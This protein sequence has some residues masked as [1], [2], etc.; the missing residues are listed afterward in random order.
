MRQVMKMLHG[1]PLVVLLAAGCAV[2]P[3]EPPQ[4]LP[5]PTIEIQPKQVNGS[6]YQAGH[7]V[8]LYDDRIARRVGDLVTVVFEESTNAKKGA[9]TNISK[10]SDTNLGV[11]IIFGRP[12]TV[13][14]NPISAS[15]SARRGF[16]GD[17]TSDQSN[18]FKGVLSSTVI[19][20]QPNGNMV[21]Q[22][23]KKI[24]LN[25]DDEYV[26]ITGVYR[27]EDVQPDNS[28]SSQRIANAQISYTGTGELADAN[29]MGW[30]SRIFNSVIWPF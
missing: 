25:R 15:A 1:I 20:V 10:D 8:R 11:P 18:L 17:A 29:S 27:R 2:A 12:V 7:D 4:P 6:I 24:T 22:G 9:S 5:Q 26:T 21:I 30:L 28:I 14:G 3:K 16:E 19:A 13:D 23:H